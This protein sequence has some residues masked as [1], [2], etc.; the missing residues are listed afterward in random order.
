MIANTN[1]ARLLKARTRFFSLVKTHNFD[2]DIRAAAFTAASC[3]TNAG[4]VNADISSSRQLSILTENYIAEGIY[5]LF[6]VVGELSDYNEEILVSF[7][8]YSN[9]SEGIVDNEEWALLTMDLSFC[10]VKYS[11]GGASLPLLFKTYRRLLD[12]CLRLFNLTE[13]DYMSNAVKRIIK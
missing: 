7:Y 8:E 13:V 12:C 2:V 11:K 4:L 10:I 5:N 1:S 3:F 9:S 6:L